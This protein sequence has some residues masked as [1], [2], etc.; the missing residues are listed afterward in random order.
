MTA[1]DPFPLPD[2]VAAAVSA[3]YEALSAY[4]TATADPAAAADEWGGWHPMIDAA[5]QSLGVLQAV[6]ALARRSCPSCP[7][8]GQPPRLLLHPEQ[9]FCGNDDCRALM[10]NPSLTA[11]QNL[12]EETPV[13]LTRDT[14]PTAPPTA[15]PAAPPAG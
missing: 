1:T 5:Q 6:D 8:C 9:A 14:P 13:Q 11:E 10:W 7:V 4:G 15:P 12:A 3:A 2:D